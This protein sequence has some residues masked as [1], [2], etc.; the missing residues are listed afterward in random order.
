MNRLRV[1]D[2]RAAFFA[3]DQRLDAWAERHRPLLRLIGS[4]LAF[5]MLIAGVAL[6]VQRSGFAHGTAAAC[7][8]PCPA[9]I[10]FEYLIA[11]MCG[12]AAIL[13]VKVYVRLSSEGSLT[14]SSM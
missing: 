4:T 1:Q 14:L 6:H 10:R 3:V 11:L 8:P 12:A 7:G 9:D 2:V 5:A 13:W